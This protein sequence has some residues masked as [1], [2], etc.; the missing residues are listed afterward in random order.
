M[1]DSSMQIQN[2]ELVAL[3]VEQ[4]KQLWKTMPAKGTSI[5]EQLS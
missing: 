3:N 5:I 1:D 2:K 4:S